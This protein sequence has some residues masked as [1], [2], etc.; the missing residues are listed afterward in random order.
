MRNRCRNS[1]RPGR[2]HKRTWVGKHGK[3]RRGGPVEVPERSDRRRSGAEQLPA[4]G[5]SGMSAAPHGRRASPIATRP[6]KTASVGPPAA[7]SAAVGRRSVWD[8]RSGLR[9]CSK[10]AGPDCC[11]RIRACW[12]CRRNQGCGSVSRVRSRAAARCSGALHPCIPLHLVDHLQR[13]KHSRPAPL[14]AGPP[15]VILSA[16]GQRLWSRCRPAAAT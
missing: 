6:A 8:A 4:G 14:P 15:H 11:G 12:Q 13:P 5:R 10:A 2:C 7:M 9:D 3:R 1:Q 16:L